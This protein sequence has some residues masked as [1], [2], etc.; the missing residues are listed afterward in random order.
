MRTFPRSAQGAALAETAS[1]RVFDATYVYLAEYS[2]VVDCAVSRANEGR[3][4]CEGEPLPSKG[5]GDAVAHDSPAPGKVARVESPRPSPFEASK[6]ESA[7][8]PP[9]GFPLEG[10]WGKHA[11]DWVVGQRAGKVADVYKT[12]PFGAGEM[13]PGPVS[14]ADDDVLCS[15]LAACWGMRAISRADD[16]TARVVVRATGR[17]TARPMNG[18]GARN[19]RIARDQV[20]MVAFKKGEGISFLSPS[21]GL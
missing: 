15:R 6:G 7:C 5:R 14:R 17:V 1:L 2:C 11:E 9:S 21:P 8:T 13:A 3:S 20:A 19:G 16:R 12:C 18:P 4:A 10:E